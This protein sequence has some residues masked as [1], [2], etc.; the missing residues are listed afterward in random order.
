MCYRNGYGCSYCGRGYEIKDD[1]ANVCRIYK[2]MSEEELSEAVDILG[3]ICSACTLEWV[4]L[5]VEDEDPVFMVAY[6][7]G[8]PMEVIT[9]DEAKR[10]LS[11]YGED[12]V[13][14]RSAGYGA[15]DQ[16]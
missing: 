14:D 15:G 4:R 5:H 12:D 11:C 8:E 3:K 1:Y 13:I 2:G 6:T 10:Y 7:P 16:L 9:E